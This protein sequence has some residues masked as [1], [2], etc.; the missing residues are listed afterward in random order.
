M[1]M[2]NNIEYIR[3]FVSFSGKC[4]YQCNHCYTYCSG[5]DSYDSGINVYEIVEGLKN[6]SFDIVYISGHKENFIDPNEGLK[7]CEEIFKN[8]HTDI[9]VT[10]RNIFTQ[11]QLDRFEKLN[12]A[13]KA[14]NKD[15]YFCASI[16][17][18]Q[19]YKRLEPN[20]IIPN[21]Y[22]R[23]ENLKRVYDRGI[24]TFLTLRPLCPDSYI[25]IKE[26][27][28]I[29]EI[30]EKSTSIVLSNGIVVDDEILNKL[31][32]F[33]QNFACQQKP[34]MPC[35]KNNLS[36]KYVDVEKELDIIKQKCKSLKLPFFEHSL[37]AIKYLK[38]K[39]D[40]IVQPSVFTI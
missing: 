13:M 34:L 25:P 17:A 37:P 3:Q 6:Q 40:S 11:E 32:G 22:Q 2:E 28:E 10:T 27:L 8:F 20:P 5:Y 21:P 18:L 24:Q 36:M 4:P 26:V 19:S 39:K 1:K 16:P 9:M 12:Y 38:K 29:I 7:L 23:M 33:P 15:L 31:K 30:C 14:E 35:L